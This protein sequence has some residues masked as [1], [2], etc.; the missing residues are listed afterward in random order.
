MIKFWNSDI[1]IASIEV[2]FEKP[3]FN[4]YDNCLLERYIKLIQFWNSDNDHCKYTNDR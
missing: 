2:K 1:D 3:N 4:A